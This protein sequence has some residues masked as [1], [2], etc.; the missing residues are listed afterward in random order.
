MKEK[1]EDPKT[2]QTVDLIHPE[3]K[4]ERNVRLDDHQK[5]ALYERAG[6]IEKEVKS[7]R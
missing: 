4:K 6:Y 7:D 5:M 3:T 1:Q 2:V